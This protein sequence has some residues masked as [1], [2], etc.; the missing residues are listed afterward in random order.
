MF[1][2]LL[3]SVNDLSAY[4]QHNLTIT[5]SIG[6]Q[7]QDLLVRTTFNHH[8]ID[9]NELISCSQATVLLRSSAG[10]NGPNVHLGKD[11]LI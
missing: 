7:I 8:T 3:T 5:S 6:H 4:S 10:H 1:F 9:A 2:L 11:I